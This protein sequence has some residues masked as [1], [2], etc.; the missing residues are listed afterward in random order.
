MHCVEKV[1]HIVAEKGCFPA[2]GFWSGFPTDLPSLVDTSFVGRISHTYGKR[3]NDV[4]TEVVSSQRERAR[5]LSSSAGVF[6]ALI[7]QHALCIFAYIFC[8][9]SVYKQ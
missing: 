9:I 7:S 2:S 6:E 3:S 5:D 4:A 1:E 8:F